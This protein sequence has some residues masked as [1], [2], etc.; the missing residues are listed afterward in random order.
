MHMKIIRLLE[1]KPHL[2]IPGNTGLTRLKHLWHWG[3]FCRLPLAEPP[4]WHSP[5]AAS[6]R[7][8]GQ[9]VLRSA[10]VPRVTLAMSSDCL[11]LHFPASAFVCHVRTLLPIRRCSSSFWGHALHPLSSSRG[12]L[13]CPGL[14]GGC[15][16]QNMKLVSSGCITLAI[17][18][19][20]GAEFKPSAQAQSFQPAGAAWRGG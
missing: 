8:T 14:G 5:R 12:P 18:E 15:G 20:P 2:A 10:V 11:F 19:K 13:Q 9:P 7:S 17:E 6:A 4:G 3:R 16:V 1:K